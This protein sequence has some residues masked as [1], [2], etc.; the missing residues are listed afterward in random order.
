MCLKNIYFALQSERNDAK[1]N[2]SSGTVHDGVVDLDKHKHQGP[3]GKIKLGHIIKW[4]NHPWYLVNTISV[5]F[6][7]LEELISP[8]MCRPKPRINEEKQVVDV[9]YI[10]GRFAP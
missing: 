6:P 1:V 2:K 3:W 5:S 9:L 8:H 7:Q 4:K 10:S